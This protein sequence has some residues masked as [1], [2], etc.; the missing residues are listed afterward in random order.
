MCV[1]EWD[2]AQRMKLKRSDLLTPALTISVADNASLKLMGAQFVK[3][4]APT[5]QTTEQVLENSTCLELLSP[6]SR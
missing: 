2:V 6:I 5:G 1:A 3:L 4:T